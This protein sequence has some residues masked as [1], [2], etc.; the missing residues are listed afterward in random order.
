MNRSHSLNSKFKSK[1]GETD[2]KDNKRGQEPP[3]LGVNSITVNISDIKA[4]QQAEKTLMQH[5]QKK[6]LK[7][8]TAKAIKDEIM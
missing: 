8:Q 4:Q 2:K 7:K 6:I 1:F 3:K 5:Q